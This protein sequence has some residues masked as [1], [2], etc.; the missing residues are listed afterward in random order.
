MAYEVLALIISE[1]SKV[2]GYAI[3]QN[4]L[5]TIG[6]KEP[7]PQK[8]QSPAAMAGSQ[9]DDKPVDYSVTPGKATAVATG[10]LPCAIGHLG[11]C[12]GLLNEATRF[13][14]EDGIVSDEVINRVN[15]CLDE[16]NTFER[17][18][19][20]PEMID[21]LPLE[22]KDLA[23]QALSISRNI[24]HTLENM[25]DSEALEHA[26][27]E[28]QRVRMDIGNKYLKGRI[29]KMTPDQKNE[30]KRALVEKLKEAREAEETE[31]A[32]EEELENA[33]SH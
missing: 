25:K 10:C 13:A 4:G 29:G 19:L 32:A 8:I 24:R 17:V 1:V 12:S 9:S 5:P 31:E 3:Q 11:T 18:D 14:R 23:R 20:R 28:I 6:K 27:G 2:V 21:G 26:A 15:M 7:E 33:S 16:L 22:E 30:V